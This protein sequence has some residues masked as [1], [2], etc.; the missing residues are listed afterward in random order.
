[1]FNLIFTWKDFDYPGIVDKSNVSNEL[2]LENVRL[3][4]NNLLFASDWTQ[5]SDSTANKVAWAEYRQ[6]LRDLPN[7][8]ADNPKDLVFPT[9]PE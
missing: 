1:M 6:S 2:I 9:P 8:Y 4:R 3:H 7:V 5:I